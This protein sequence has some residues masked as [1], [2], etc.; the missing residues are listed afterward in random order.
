MSFPKGDHFLNETEHVPVGLSQTPVK[1]TCVVVLAVSVVVSLLCPKHFVT[2]QDHGDTV[3]EQQDGNHVF[4]LL[5]S[6]GQY[7]WDLGFPFIPA[8]PTE[9]VIAAIMVGLL[10]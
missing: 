1:P 4:G 2:K 5:L 9:V 6:E 8:V 7:L 3:A 10:L